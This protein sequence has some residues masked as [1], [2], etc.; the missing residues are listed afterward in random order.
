MAWTCPEYLL[1]VT[2]HS[3]GFTGITRHIQ[4]G[5]HIH[6]ALSDSCYDSRLVTLV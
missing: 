2:A 3:L 4:N 5:K 1:Q 6:T